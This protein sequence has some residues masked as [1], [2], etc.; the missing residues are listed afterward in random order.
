MNRKDLDAELEEEEQVSDQLDQAKKDGDLSSDVAKLLELAKGKKWDE[1]K[2]ALKDFLESKLGYVYGYPEPTDGQLVH[3]RQALQALENEEFDSAVMHLEKADGAAKQDDY[4]GDGRELP[5]KPKPEETAGYEYVYD[6]NIRPLKQSQAGILQAALDQKAPDDETRAEVLEQIA[7][8]AELAVSTVRSIISG[9]MKCPPLHCLRAAAEVLDVPLDDLIAAG[10]AEGCEYP[11]PDQMKSMSLDERQKKV[12]DAWYDFMGNGGCGCCPSGIG[13]IVEVF[14]DHVIVDHKRKCFRLAYA[15]DGD[16]VQFSTNWIPV[17]LEKE[18]VEIPAET[19]ALGRYVIKMLE[20]DCIGGYGIYFG[21]EDEHDL[22]EAKDFFTPGTDLWLE[23]TGLL[24]G[25]AHQP[26]IYEHGLEDQTAADPVAGRWIKA[27]PDDVGVWFEGELSKAHKYEQEIKKLIEAG[28][29][30]ISTDTAPHLIIRQ[31][32]KNGA[33][34]LVRWPVLAASLTTHA[35]EP[36]LLPVETLK[37]AYK[38]LGDDGFAARLQE[39]EVTMN[40]EL[41]E[42]ITN[43]VAAKVAPIDVDAIATKAAEAVMKRL[44]EEP[45]KKN[46]GF[47]AGA[48]YFNKL[49]KDMDNVKAFEMWLRQ[50]LHGMPDP[51]K[52]LLRPVQLIESEGGRVEIKAIGQATGAA[53]GFLV[54]REYMDEISLP[55]FEQSHLRQAKARIITIPDTNYLEF[56]TLTGSAAATL[57]AEA[58]AYADAT[59][60]FGAVAFQPYKL[61]KLAKV[62]DEAL[63]DSR[64]DIWKEVLVPD[65]GQAFAAGENTYFTTGTGTAQPQGVVTG[66]AAGITTAS[67]TVITTDELF[68]LFFQVNHNYRV[69]PSAGWMMNDAILQYVAKLKDADGRYM[70][71]GDLNKGIPLSIMGKEVKIN[72]SMASTV[73]TTNVTILFGAFWYFAIGDREGMVV[74]RLEELYAENGQVGFRAYKRVDSHILQSAAIKKMTQA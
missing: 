35:A 39:L 66:A 2:D 57:V 1:L 7:E 6:I 26:L 67:A 29:L 24:A 63:A 23:A 70:L 44:E 21:S 49:P 30:R 14:D 28:K 40:Q 31:E 12:Y 20:G 52:A 62:A 59:P 17:K 69:H 38:S 27:A 4:Y 54:P 53:G 50:G 55:M 37:A 42:Q 5:P 58:G 3:L 60:T 47:I 48:P 19:K 72:N 51:V 65:W 73:A 13:Y 61:T 25:K 71:T 64:F 9:Q 10:R 46:V 22:T 18:W 56:P 11:E 32:R 45:S 74:K 41:I 34:E 36:R 16:R 8:K 68:D 43:A 15:V 33:H